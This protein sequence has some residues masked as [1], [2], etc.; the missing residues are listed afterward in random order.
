MLPLT[1]ISVLLPCEDLSEPVSFVT[2]PLA[3]VQ[4]FIIVIAV[5]VTLPQVL[6]PL[7]MV[8]IIGP[9]L[10]VSTVEDTMA[11]P[12]VSSLNEYLTLILI[13]IAISI[14]RNHALRLIFT[15]MDPTAATMA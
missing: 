11:I 15:R 3:H 7:A 14:L 4:I 1:F 6:S 5:A 8:L 12:D 10:L 9:F 2:L 13:T